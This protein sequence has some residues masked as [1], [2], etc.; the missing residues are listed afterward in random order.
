MYPPSLHHT[1]NHTWQREDGSS[2]GRAMAPLSGG[3]GF[4][5]C[6]MLSPAATVLGYLYRSL[7]PLTGLWVPG[8]FILLNNL[9]L[10]TY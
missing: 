7:F 3:Q 8:Y 1:C 10:L 2:V 9:V 4:K 6:T 5:A